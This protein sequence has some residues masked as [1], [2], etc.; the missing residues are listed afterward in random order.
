[1]KKLGSTNYNSILNETVTFGIFHNII[2]K[3][4]ESVSIYRGPGV[5]ITKPKDATEM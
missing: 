1:M 5:Q 4:L 3:I 2:H